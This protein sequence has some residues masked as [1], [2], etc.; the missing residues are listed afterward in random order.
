MMRYYNSY[1]IHSFIKENQIE[2]EEE[3]NR[4]L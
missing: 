4:D 3:W 2:Y 1:H